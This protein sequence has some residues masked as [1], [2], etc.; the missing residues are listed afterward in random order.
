MTSAGGSGTGE[1]P[2]PRRSPGAKAASWLAFAASPAFAVMAL[3]SAVSGGD[4]PALLCG[5]AHGSPF[6]GM[7]LMYLLMSAFHAGPWLK[8]IG[9]RGE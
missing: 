9:G 7:T 1:S 2:L 6:T 3:L 4:A 8:A 5:A